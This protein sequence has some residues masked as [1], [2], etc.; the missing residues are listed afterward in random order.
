MSVSRKTK[1]STLALAGAL[2]FSSLSAFTTLESPLAHAEDTPP[3]ST[4]DDGENSSTP[5]SSTP[6]SSTPESSTNQEGDNSNNNPDD[7]DKCINT[8]LNIALVVDNSIS[9]E[10]HPEL[11]KQVT[12][13]YK[14][15]I[16]TAQYID[17][18]AQITVFPVNIFE[19]APHSF[20]SN[21][22]DL[23]KEEDKK[24]IDS[25]I[26]NW[27]FKNKDGQGPW[28]EQDE[29]GQDYFSRGDSD[30]FSAVQRVDKM[31]DDRGFNLMV[32]VSDGKIM[33]DNAQG[34]KDVSQLGKSLRDKGV[35]IK[36]FIGSDDQEETDKFSSPDNLV[37]KMTSD[38][39]EK[40]KDYFT[41]DSSSLG[42]S[43]EK[44]LNNYC[45]DNGGDIDS[46]AP[47][48]TEPLDDNNNDQ[49][50]STN[51]PEPSQQG[52]NGTN[53]DHKDKKNKKHKKHKKPRAHHNTGGINQTISENHT[54]EAS[55]SVFGFYGFDDNGNYTLLSPGEVDLKD[56]KIKNSDDLFD[57]LDKTAFNF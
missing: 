29:L 39:P 36:S 49:T 20:Y 18:A 19:F 25:I 54:S 47:S 57:Y 30:F 8:S 31:T 14:K 37:A 44:V 27:E 21:T 13:S 23:S 50:T 7:G 32:T 38:N 48:T 51:T 15:F 55:A 16:D 33:L 5:E 17:P 45:L 26:D 46:N 10:D 40:D 4:S 12:E 56:Q 2:S 42:D 9:V 3:V 52:D 1:I 53:K 6:E 43:L 41:V 35:T 22:F 11:K 24:T 28:V 34:D